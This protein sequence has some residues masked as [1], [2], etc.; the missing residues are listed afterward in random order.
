M[1]V[2]RDYYRLWVSV[3]TFK[4][5]SDVLNQNSDWA[6]QTFKAPTGIMVILIHSSTGLSLL[7]PRHHI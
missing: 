7:R 5:Y 3:M 6:L 4:F 2:H 1:S